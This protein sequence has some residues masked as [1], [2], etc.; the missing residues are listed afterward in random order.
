MSLFHLMRGQLCHWALHRAF[1]HPVLRQACFSPLLIYL[2]IYYS[3]LSSVCLVCQLITPLTYGICTV[4]H[5]HFLA[6]LAFRQ[7]QRSP[8][9][10]TSSL[11]LRLP[12]LVWGKGG[13][14]CAL[15]RYMTGKS[16]SL[17]GKEATLRARVRWQ[18]SRYWNLRACETIHGFKLTTF[19]DSTLREYLKGE[20]N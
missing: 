6:N 17:H 20:N 13:G 3:L 4:N 2:L 5:Q 16:P 8:L 11:M 15:P 19:L 10:A 9:G 14:S 7:T 18:S 1:E 12:E